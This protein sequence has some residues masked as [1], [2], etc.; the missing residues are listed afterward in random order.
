[1]SARERAVRAWQPRPY[2]QR[3]TLWLPMFAGAV[4]A[5]LGAIHVVALAWDQ[6]PDPP[7]RGGSRAQLDDQGDEHA[8]AASA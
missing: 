4:G 1:M 6:R 7:P 5:V 2:W 3:L 8:E